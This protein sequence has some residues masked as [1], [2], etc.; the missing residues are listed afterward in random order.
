MSG[1]VIKLGVIGWPI[2]HS[3]SP[4]IH[5]HWLRALDMAG[6]YTLVPIDPQTNFRHALQALA[7]NGYC[8]AN[9]TL[10]HKE[11]AFAAMDTVSVTAKKLGAV[12][13]ISFKDGKMFGDNT[14][15]GGYLASLDEAAPAHDW[16]ARPA[17]VIGAGGAARAICVALAAAGVPQIRLVNRT[18]ARADA[19]VSLAPK[20]IETDDWAHRA[21]AAKGCGL[22][23]NTTGLGMTHQP[24]LDMSLEHVDDDALVS[25]IVYTPL[26]TEL[27]RAAQTRGLAAVGGLGMLIHQ[28][29]LAF[30]IWFG[31]TPPI[32]ARLTRKLVADIEDR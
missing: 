19:L 3:R 31:Q 20:I 5:N 23:V 18:R 9:V 27:M 25:D 13:T 22:V 32:D 4:L 17:L 30:E 11:N 12:N 10:P 8:G 6:D 26:Q 28:A 2:S 21:G 14:D 24:A 1:D 7:D 15:G 29:A 16:R